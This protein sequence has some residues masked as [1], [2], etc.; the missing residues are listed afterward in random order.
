MF[1]GYSTILPEKRCLRKYV[2]MWLIFRDNCQSSNYADILNVESALGAFSFTNV[3][4]SDGSL[5]NQIGLW[6]A[7]IIWA[8]IFLIKIHNYLKIFLINVMLK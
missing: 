2:V 4:L 3:V 6:K 1:N 5:F 7:S 8:I